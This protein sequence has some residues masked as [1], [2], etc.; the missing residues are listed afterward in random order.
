MEDVTGDLFS[1]GS[2]LS[3]GQNRSSLN[4][5]DSIKETQEISTRILC[6]SP[7]NIA[8][9]TV[10]MSAYTADFHKVCVYQC[11]YTSS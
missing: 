10:R 3:T 5:M 11:L 1:G 2:K 4:R 8:A 7:R 9:E 6:Q